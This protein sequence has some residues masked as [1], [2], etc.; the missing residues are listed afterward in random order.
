MWNNSAKLELSCHSKPV[1]LENQ[2][3][4]K[5]SI[6][7]ALYGPS[8]MQSKQINKTKTI[9]NSTLN[10]KK[11]QAWQDLSVQLDSSILYLLPNIFHKVVFWS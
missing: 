10:K 3:Q 9:K 6:L 1:E 2:Q 7:L 8:W 5:E 4:G 11:A